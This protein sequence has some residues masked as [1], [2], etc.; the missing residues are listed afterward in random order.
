MQAL[1]AVRT[2]DNIGFR[3]DRRVFSGFSKEDGN[4]QI[5]L[6]PRCASRF[7]L[8]VGDLLCL[9]APAGSGEVSL[10]VF[11][12]Q[13]KNHL[14]NLGL[15]E[16]GR[17]PARDFDSRALIGW[18][19]SMGGEGTQ[20]WPCAAVKLGAEPIVLK[21][22]EACTVWTVNPNAAATLIFGSAC[23]TILASHQPAR[24]VSR[25]LPPPLGD[26][27]EEF[28]IDRA[29]AC[30]Y[31]LA[32]GEMVQ[33]IDVEG[34]QCSDFMAFRSDGLQRGKELM[35]DGTATRSMVRRA[36]PGPGLFDKFYDMDMRPLLN[37]VQDT[38]G[39]H[40]TFGL[41][42]TSRSYEERGF[43][44]HVSCSDNMSEALAP[45]GVARRSAWPAINFFW[46]T[47]VDPSSHH[48]LTEESHSR[49]GDHVVLRAMDD[50][51]CV[52][53]ACPDD[54]DPI[55]GWNPTDIH[56]RI[57]QP[58]SPIRRAV[59]Y[60][61]KEDAPMSVSEE[62]AFHP[63]TSALTDHFAPAR[64][65]WAPVSY[66]AI[67]TL[68]EYWA[69]REAVT[70]QDMS[71]LRKYDVVGPDAERLLQQAMTR[72]ISKLSIWRG[73]YTLLCDDTGAVIDDGTLFRMGEHLFRWCCGSE[74]SAR[75]LDALAQAMGLQ[76]RINAMGGSLPNLALQ[77]PR[78]RDLLRKIAF[79]QPH[80]PALE[81]VKWFGATVARL[82]DREGIPF[83]LTRSGYTGELGYELFCAGSDAVALWDAIMEAGA[84]FGIRPMGSDALETIRIEAGLAAAG[85]EFA[86]GV[87]AF[88]AGLGFAVDLR[89]VDFTGKAA[90]ERNAQE[91]RKALKGLLL[92]GDDVPRHGAPVLLG[93]RQVG[94]VTSATR[95]PSLQRAIAMVRLA[96]E[97]AETGRSLDVG[98]MDGHMKR[99]PATVTEIPFIDP[100]RKRARA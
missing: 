71:G 15:S 48:I 58:D 2:L 82:G 92:N 5:S 86:P 47:W 30:A 85:A 12:R 4:R 94:V 60:R 55:N 43:P 87:D 7:D 41:A 80:V 66:P 64:D 25:V 59:A 46:N 22:E 21:A 91:P 14:H 33:I 93:E 68:A 26:V 39:R 42:C 79:T 72:D 61:E 76:V 27:K 100:Q 13:G 65:L 51:V 52:S 45:Y 77:G 62:S 29:T 6:N 49:P 84:E 38:C 18:I 70:L 8:A 54:I 35:I 56:V 40:D 36:Y 53:T 99:L 3:S 9:S 37:V 11:G 96:V 20:S 10:I 63:R 50:L 34:Q 1:S 97:H 32:A 23:P 75:V 16:T 78:S 17:V 81:Q 31:E 74:E 28:T 98:Q 89:K 83:M 44:G 73:T 24:T 95:S 90:L 67:G 88:E 57:Y 19:L 69:C